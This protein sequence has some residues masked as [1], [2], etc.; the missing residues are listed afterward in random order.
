MNIRRMTIDD[1]ERLNFDEQWKADNYV[2][3]L[4][5]EVGPAWVI[6]SDSGELLCGFGAAF[7]WQGVCEVWFNLVKKEKTICVIR[8]VKRY[9]AEQVKTLGIK[10]MHATVKC[11]FE[12]GRKFV[13]SLGFRCETPFGMKNYN[14]DGSAA[15]LFSRV[16]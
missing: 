2:A 15:Y 9:L 13:E 1:I 8:L 5:N 16:F 7:L 14:P 3:Y 12:A 10:R 11:D 6:E 4:K